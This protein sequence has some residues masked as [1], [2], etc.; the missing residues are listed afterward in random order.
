MII[1]IDAEKVIDKIQYPFMV[2][3]KTKTTLQ[4]SRHRRNIT[5]HDKSHIRQTYSKHYPQWG[6]INSI[7]SKIKN[8]SRMPTLTITIQHSFGSPRHSSQ[9][10]KR[11]KRNPDWK[12][13]L[14]LFADDVILYIENPKDTT[15]K[16]LELINEYRKASGY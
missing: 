9:R 2:K 6:K 15:I 7:S 11:N 1:S 16:L 13:K 14:S 4:K 10:R 3:T 12:R 8:K 5:Q